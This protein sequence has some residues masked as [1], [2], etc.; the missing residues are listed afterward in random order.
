MNNSLDDSLNVQELS[1]L[2]D[3]DLRELE[4]AISALPHIFRW[5]ANAEVC[6]YFV[7]KNSHDTNLQHAWRQPLT[8]SNKPGH[9]IVV[10]AVQ[11]AERWRHATRA[12]MLPLKWTQAPHAGNVPHSLLEVADQVSERL[13]SSLR[14]NEQLQSADASARLQATW[15]LSWSP[16][17]WH[18]LDLSA[19]P[20]SA[21]S[22]WAPLAI[23]LASAMLDTHLSD[24]LLATGFWD[25]EQNAWSVGPETLPSKL[26]AG[27]EAGKRLFVV[28]A[29]VAQDARSLFRLN[30]QKDAQVVELVDDPQDIYAGVLPGLLQAGAEPTSTEPRQ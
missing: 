10:A 18:H 22:A 27:Y 25:S 29:S 28:P 13:R 8:I 20:L 1:R 26:S 3:L 14:L 24:D 5:F 2:L 19:L 9:V 6:R 30:E 11:A 15:G 4:R 12:F 21:E 17:D 23:G 16:A 7:E